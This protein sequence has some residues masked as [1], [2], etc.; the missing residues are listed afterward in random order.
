MKA[1]KIVSR[2]AYF[3][4]IASIIF[5]IISAISTYFLLQIASSGAPIEYVAFYI[6]STML[7]YLLLTAISLVVAVICGGAGEENVE[8]E[9]ELPPAEPAEE[10]A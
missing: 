1:T 8:T 4:A 5:A 7:P 2:I 6:L 3:S 9:D 10:K